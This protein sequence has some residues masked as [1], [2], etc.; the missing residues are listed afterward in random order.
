MADTKTI[1]QVKRMVEAAE[2]PPRL[3]L[4]VAARERV[5]ERYERLLESWSRVLAAMALHATELAE[6]RGVRAV[7]GGFEI[8]FAWQADVPPICDLNVI[9]DADSRVMVVRV[10]APGSEPTKAS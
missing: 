4:E 10:L 1:D 5:I 6:G 9:E 8:P 2:R 3:F 7:G